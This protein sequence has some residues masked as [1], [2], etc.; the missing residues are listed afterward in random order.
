MISRYQRPD[1]AAIWSDKNRFQIMF[2]IELLAAKAMAEA[3]RVPM[4]FYHSLN[5]ISPDQI[6]PKRVAELE[7]KIRHETVALLTHI[8]ELAGPDGVRFLHLGMTSSDVLDTCLSL[9][10]NQAADLIIDGI[11]GLCDALKIQAQNHKLTLCA[12]RSHG[13]HA[14]PTTFGLKMAQAFAEMRR[15]RARMV[16]ARQQISFGAVS[17]PVGTF[18]HIDPQIEAQICQ[19]LHLKPEPISTQVIPRDRHAAYFST[20]GVISSSLERIAIELRSL[21]R[22][23]IGEIEEAFGTDQTGSSA[24]P[25]KKNPILAENIT[26]LARLIRAQVLAALENVSLW[27]ERDMSHSSVERMI[28]PDMTLA[29]DFVLHRMTGII[30]HMNVRKDRMQDNLT[31][32]KGRYHSHRVLTALVDAGA[33]RSEAHRLVQIN[34][35]RAEA[36]DIPFILALELDKSITS[37]LP[38]KVLR[39]LF[40]DDHYTRNIETLFHRIFAPEQ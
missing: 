35:T 2:Q 27:H 9:Q 6:D 34:A 33:T 13:M 20:L 25:H 1:M 11:D 32:T 31:L 21:Q 10:L 18:S 5:K 12:G 17:G 37:Y 19:S 7:R 38:H 36:E 30:T 15:N 8:E 23:E 14:E 40:D 24:M 22:T 29:L 28:A 4:T 16:S 39:S 26:G 3:G